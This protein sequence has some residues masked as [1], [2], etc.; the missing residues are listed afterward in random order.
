MS[1]SLVLAGV[2]SVVCMFRKALAPALR[3]ISFTTWALSNLSYA[4]SHTTT[5]I[6]DGP[7]SLQ[8]QM[9]G[10]WWWCSPLTDLGRRWSKSRGIVRCRLSA[11]A[12]VVLFLNAL[13]PRRKCDRTVCLNLQQFLHQGLAWLSGTL[14]G[15]AVQVKADESVQILPHKVHAFVFVHRHDINAVEA[16]L[17]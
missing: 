4:V 13:S 14:L 15:C 5:D 1:W 9:L 3:L 10:P 7:R 2:V 11:S 16:T 17:A 8:G 12:S 6:K